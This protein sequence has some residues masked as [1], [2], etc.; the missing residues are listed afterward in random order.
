MRCSPPGRLGRVILDARSI[1][2][3]VAGQRLRVVAV[4]PSVRPRRGGANERPK[5]RRRPNSSVRRRRTPRARLGI[6]H[7]FRAY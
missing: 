3:S 6:C 5:R 4:R 1:D 2:R 7:S